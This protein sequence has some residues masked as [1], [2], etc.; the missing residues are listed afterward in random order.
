[1]FLEPTIQEL[2]PDY[3]EFVDKAFD[4]QPALYRGAMSHR[5]DLLPTSGDVDQLLDLEVLPP[6][7]V[8]LT[9]D[10]KG[11]ARN[12]SMRL[13]GDAPK[14]PVVDSAKI[15]E[16]F[17]SGATLSINDLQQVSP[18]LRALIRPLEREFLC[19]CEAVVFATPAGR[20]GFAPHTDSISV[21]VVQCEG[22]KDWRVWP[23]M[24]DGAR[25]DATYDLDALKEPLLEVTLAPGDVLYLPHGTPHA[26]AARHEQSV[27]VSLGLRP[28]PWPELIGRIISRLAAACDPTGFPA[29]NEANVPNLVGELKRHLAVLTD[30]LN[31]LDP[32]AA[33]TALRSELQDELI[34]TPSAG[35]RA[36]RELDTLDVEQHYR[37]AS[38]EIKV[39]GKSED[40]RCR[41]QIQG[42][43]MNLPQVIVDSL[44]SVDGQDRVLSCEQIYPGVPIGR[45]MSAVKQLA[46]VGALVA[47]DAGTR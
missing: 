25:D 40:N 9:R 39:L 15:Y 22:T 20:N 35:L 21:I 5:P 44:T 26:A 24:I 4:L 38:A 41:V 36:I 17:R 43:T 46:R 18:Q 37:V 7:Y 12:A 23:T 45:A 28:R 11:L 30:A 13:V 14:V 32:E 42:V 6:D 8:R 1:M 19:R 27:H 34:G 10:G 33:L 31:G 2:I 29:L 3:P 47:V 16:L